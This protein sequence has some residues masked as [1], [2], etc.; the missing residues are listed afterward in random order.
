MAAA[1]VACHNFTA[2]S[3][4]LGA[5]TVRTGERKAVIPGPDRGRIEINRYAGAV[6]ETEVATWLALRCQGQSKLIRR[7]ST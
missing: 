3:A 5:P 7:R 6:P 4:Y 1:P 2:S